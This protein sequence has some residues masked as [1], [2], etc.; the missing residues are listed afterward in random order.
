[1]TSTGHKESYI[2][3]KSM[4]LG[5]STMLGGSDDA[6][7]EVLFVRHAETDMNLKK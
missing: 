2:I 4:Y 7:K 3:N 1:M 5:A 6:I